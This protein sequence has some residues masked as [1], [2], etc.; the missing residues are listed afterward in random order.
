LRHR[1]EE[2]VRGARLLSFGSNLLATRPDP[3]RGIAALRALEFYAHA[4]FFSSAMSRDADILFPVAMPWERQGL[5]AGFFVNQAAEAL[6]QLRT[7]V[8]VPQGE[9]RSDAAIAF[10]WRIDW[11]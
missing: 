6:V 5:Q 8:V 1:G 11:V 2:T 3:Q 10:A 7:P 9:A 4:D